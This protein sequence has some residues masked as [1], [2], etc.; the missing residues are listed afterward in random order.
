MTVVAYH[1]YVPSFGDWG[2]NM[3]YNY[4]YDIDGIDERITGLQYYSHDTFKQSLH[5]PLDA[6]ISETEINTFNKP[7]LYTYYLKGWKYYT[8]M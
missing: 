7:V 8:E 2:F 3:A 5:F 6:G 1:V 4:K